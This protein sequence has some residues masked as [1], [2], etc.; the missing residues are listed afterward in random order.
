MPKLRSTVIKSIGGTE[1]TGHVYTPA[2]QTC[3]INTL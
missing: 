1:Y 2:E 3:Y